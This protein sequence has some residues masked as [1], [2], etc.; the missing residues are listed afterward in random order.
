LAKYLDENIIPDKK[1]I[2][3]LDDFRYII[4]RDMEIIITTYPNYR[5]MIGTLINDQQLMNFVAINILPFSS[6]IFYDAYFKTI[7]GYGYFMELVAEGVLWENSY[8]PDYQSKSFVISHIVYSTILRKVLPTYCLNQ[9]ENF[10]IPITN[11][12]LINVPQLILESLKYFSS[13]H[14]NLANNFSF[15]YNKT[16]GLDQDTKVPKEAVYHFQLYYILCSIIPSLYGLVFPE[17]NLPEY[18]RNDLL[19]IYTSYNY[20]FEII[21]SPGKKDFLNHIDRQKNRVE[22]IQNLHHLHINQ[23][24]IFV[25]FCTESLDILEWKKERDFNNIIF[26]QHALN[27]TN[28]NFYFDEIIVSGLL[29]V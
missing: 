19:L 16:P 8:N 14:L 29:K 23:S 12:G 6:G 28:F 2:P 1:E 4:R 24:W 13:S 27:P 3:T 17:T 26:I 5:K 11:S 15:K 22:S 9:I 21:S 20:Y 18:N 7:D 25:F 10:Y